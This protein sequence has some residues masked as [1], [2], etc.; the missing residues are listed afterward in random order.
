MSGNDFKPQLKF[1]KSAKKEWDALD[2]K[3]RE[4]FKKK[5]KKR[6]QSLEELKPQKHK[7]SGVERCYKIKL[8]SD[9]YR[10]V[11]QVTETSSGKFSI[12][13]TVITVDRRE[14]VYETLKTK[15]K[16]ADADI[17][18]SL[19]IIELRDDDE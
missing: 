9:G 19:R 18:D 6:A 7:L 13:I 3:V 17:S 8:R 5:L 14:D 1:K 12:V 4:S 10:L 16:K 11:Y 15:L 2:S